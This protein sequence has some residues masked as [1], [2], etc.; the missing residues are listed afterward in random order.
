MTNTAAAIIP[1]ERPRYARPMLPHSRSDLAYF[2]MK[3]A[4]LLRPIEILEQRIA[5]AT[6]MFTDVDGDSVTVTTSKGT[7]GALSSVAHFAASGGGQVLQLL[8]LTTNPVFQ[9]TD[10]SILVTGNNAGHVDVGFID[11]TNLDLGIGHHRGGS[12]QDRRR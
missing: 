4:I 7:D 12:R 8:S 3:K 9:G 10:L 2:T 1:L 6:L 11:A 5:P